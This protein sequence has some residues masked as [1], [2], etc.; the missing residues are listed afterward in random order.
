MR[1]ASRLV[2]PDYAFPLGGF[3]RL[4]DAGSFAVC[5]RNELDRRPSQRGGVEHDVAGLGGQPSEAMPSS[6]CR[7]SGIGMP[8]RLGLV[9]VRTSSRPSSTAKNGLPAVASRTRA[10]S[11]RVRSSPARSLSRL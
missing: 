9:F 7:L 11:G 1:E 5:G 3:Q 2:E 6:S 4:E 10:S 8:G